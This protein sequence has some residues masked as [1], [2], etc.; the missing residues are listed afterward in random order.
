MRKMSAPTAITKT[1][2]VRPMIISVIPNAITGARYEGSGRWIDSVGGGSEP[3]GCST[4]FV[5]IG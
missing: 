4:S 1:P 5:A 3:S 2:S